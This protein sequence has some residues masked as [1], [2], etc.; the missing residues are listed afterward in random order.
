M[1]TETEENIKK[2]EEARCPICIDH[3]H[4]AIL[5]LCS[6][7]K[8]G[9]RP[10][11]CNTSRRH[12]NCFTQ[13]KKSKKISFGQTKSTLV[14]P[15]CRGEVSGWT[16]EEPARLFMNHKQRTCAKDNSNFSGTYTDLK[17]HARSS[18]HPEIGPS[19]AYLN[20]MQYMQVLNDHLDRL[21]ESN[22]EIEA[23]LAQLRSDLNSNT[24][25]I[26]GPAGNGERND[27][28]RGRLFRLL[29]RV[30]GM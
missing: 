28:F 12:S 18:A 4:N 21:R 15:L 8:N 25:L 17:N 14:C 20:A 13:F 16:V 2:W 29:L 30:V 10:Y 6:S 23:E 9:Y 1:P 26:N 22:R 24:S 7:H 11:I 27:V 19:E 5:L 3:P